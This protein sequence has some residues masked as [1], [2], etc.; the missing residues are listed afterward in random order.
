M[1]LVL[2]VH[3]TT[4]PAGQR[5]YRQL[6]ARVAAHVPT[7][8]A[9][10][11]VQTPTLADVVRR[12]DVVVPVLLA[13]GYHVRVDCEQ[14]LQRRAVLAPA[15]GPDPA[16]VALADERLR[17]AGAGDDWPVVLAAAG[18]RDATARADLQLAADR[19]GRRRGQRVEL[20]FAS[21]PGEVAAT[22]ASVRDRTGGPVGV[23]TWLLAPG[24]FAET[25]SASGADAVGAALGAHASVVRVVL[26]RWATAQEAVAA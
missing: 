8:L 9:H 24:R 5:V 14:A 22:V 6:A 12:G 3:G 23:A 13:R 4:S 16:L 11:D 15:V 26:Q 17:A 1:R 18:S 21:R 7:A 2:A 19:L 10:L 20:A 25:V